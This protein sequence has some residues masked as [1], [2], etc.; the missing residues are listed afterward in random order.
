MLRK[1]FATFVLW[2]SL[3]GVTPVMADAPVTPYIVGGPTQSLTPGSFEWSWDG[4]YIADFRAALQNPANF[5][6][7]G[8]V[9][10]SIATV[11]LSTVD[12]G[13]LAGVNMFVATWI[14]NAE[15]SVSQTQAVVDF[16]L[17]GG[18][19]FL[20][21]DDGNHDV[22]GRALGLLT[23][24][25]SGSVSN[26]GAPLYDGPFGVAS[27]VTQHYLV[28]RL[29]E[30]AVLSLRGTVAGRNVQGEVTSAFWAA[31]QF[32][33][34]AGA[35]FINA[36]IDMIANT[37]SQCGLAVCGARYDPLNNNGVFALNTFAF[38]Q[39]QGGTPPIPEPGS[40][41]LLGLGLAAVVATA[42]RRRA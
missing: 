38:L 14:P 20:L 8:V 13:S 16:F 32:A 7:A 33:P 22:I 9:D 11:N 27:D 28:G 39:E 35:L 5:G 21:Q 30:A 23:F 31:G 15:F 42:R 3:G 2:G 36:D 18:D 19:L 1:L 41:A 12:A 34:G 26:G 40:F 17:G 37:G 24:A 6:P 25:S 10:R 29:D 4:A